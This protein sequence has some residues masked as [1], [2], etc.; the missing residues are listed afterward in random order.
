MTE[1]IDLAPIN[2]RSQAW[3]NQRVQYAHSVLNDDID[4]LLAEVDRLRAALD[5]PSMLDVYTARIRELEAERDE[6]RGES[7][8]WAAENARLA[9]RLATTEREHDG[10]REELTRMAGDLDDAQA[11]ANLRTGQLRAARLR[12]DRLAATV[13]R[14][15]A[16]AADDSMRSDA[17]HE[18]GG[19]LIE[20]ALLRAALSATELPA[21]TEPTTEPGMGPQRPTGA[22]SGPVSAEPRTTRHRSHVKRQ[23]HDGTG[24]P[25]VCCGLTKHGM[26]CCGLPYCDECLSGCHVCDDE[27]VPVD[28]EPMSAGL[29]TSSADTGGVRSEDVDLPPADGD[30]H[31]TDPRPFEDLRST[32]LLWL[33]NAAV[34]HPR[35]FA[36]ALCYD[37]GQIAGW[38]LLGDGSEPWRFEGDLID[39]HFGEVEALFAAHRAT[40]DAQERA[41]TV[42]DHPLTF[43]CG[44]AGAVYAVCG[45][46]WASD[47]WG[48]ERD[49]TVDHAAHVHVALGLAVD[50]ASGEAK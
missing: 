28:V 41:E 2:E 35:G 32:G 45:C 14:V 18:C 5:T 26:F 21:A 48:N 6:A 38:R 16:V 44:A 17:C 46:G 43:R 23:V 19:G 9:E 7:A 8:A 29:T 1:P 47:M 20:P 36:L 4:T 30:R 42:E 37:R 24:V 12:G 27:P 50:D 10:V 11:T 22:D 39:R 13:E 33:I 40:G 3:H 25:C 34:F 49:A 15:R 31:R